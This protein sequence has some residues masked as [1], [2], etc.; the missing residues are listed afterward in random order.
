M[1]FVKA[2]VVDTLLLSEELDEK[3]IEEFETEANR[4]GTI[5]RIISTETRKSSIKR[6]RKS[7]CHSQV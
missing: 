6:N 5:I 7:S 2:G 1:N 4:F 3:K